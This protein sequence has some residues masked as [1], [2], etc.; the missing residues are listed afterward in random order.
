[1]KLLLLC[2]IIAICSCQGGPAGESVPFSFQEQEATLIRWRP[3]DV[4]WPHYLPRGYRFQ[5]VSYLN[6]KRGQ[7][8]HLRFTN[9][10]KLLSIF[11]KPS[12]RGRRK[13]KVKRKNKYT[14]V[15]WR[16]GGNDFTLIGRE[17]TGSLLKIA[18]SIR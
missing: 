3:P 12:S 9:D 2:L 18:E 14:I 10:K 11:I 5:G 8:V 7:V 16:K 15:E 4:P 17:S 13:W 6:T 1:M